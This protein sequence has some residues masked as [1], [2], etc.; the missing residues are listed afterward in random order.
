MKH[1]TRRIGWMLWSYTESTCCGVHLEKGWG[2]SMEDDQLAGGQPLGVILVCSLSV[3]LPSSPVCL[4][5]QPSYHPLPLLPSVPP[6]H[7]KPL[8]NARLIPVLTQCIL[9]SAIRDSL[10]WDVGF[11]IS[12]EDELASGLE[13]MSTTQSCCV[14]EVLLQWK[15]RETS[16]DLDIG[17]RQ[18][19]PPHL[20]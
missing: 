12:K 11:M 4:C 10:W 19:V 14:T 2:G 3:F 17:S 18:S 15:G 13:T 20:S 9:L 8:W 7:L 16:S 1:Y 6:S 5:S